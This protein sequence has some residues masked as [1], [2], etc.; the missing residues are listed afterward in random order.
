MGVPKLFRWLSE[1]YPCLSQIVKDNEVPQ[2]DNLY[3]DMNG[4]IHNCSHPCDDDVHFRLPEDQIIQDIFSYIECLFNIIK[5]KKIFFM[6]VDGVAP[7][8]KMNQQ[9][10]RRFRS[11]RDAMERERQAT[12]RGEKLSD[13]P[14]F[15][16]N[17]IT[18]GTDFMV[19]LQK[20]LEYFVA[21]KISTDELWKDIKVILSG[22]EAPGEGEHKIMDFIRTER[23]QDNYDPNT[24][25]CLYGL[26]AD[27][28][29]L[30]VSSHEPY[31][32]LLREEV[33]F[34]RSKAKHVNRVN[35]SAITFH[36]LHLTLLRDYLHHEFSSLQDKLP[37]GYDLESIIDDWI[38]MSFL[39]GNDFIPPIPHFQISKNT[40]STLYR[41]YMEVA[42][43]LDGYLNEKGHLNLKRFQKFL[44]KLSQVDFDNF[45]ETNAD[46]KY[47]NSKRHQSKEF[48]HQSSKNGHYST[49]NDTSPNDESPMISFLENSSD[50]EGT[51]AESSSENEDNLLDDEF[52]SHKRDY[53]MTK[54]H[55]EN[56]NSDVLKEQAYCYIKAIQWNLHYYYD[57]CPSW[58][59]FYPHHYAPYI[60]D[61]KSFED[62][63]LN[64]ELG[65]PFK[66]YEQLLG[67]LPTASKQFLPEAYQRLMT[68]ESSPLI[69]YF[70]EN[71][72]LDLDGKQ[73][74]WEAV[75]VIPFIDEVKLLS[76]TKSCE[77]KLSEGD[78]KQNKHGPHL[79]FTFTPDIQSHISSTL[80]G[81]LP[82]IT[83]NH[84]KVTPVSLDAY[85]LPR[86]KIKKGLIDGVDLDAYVPGFPTLRTLAHTAELKRAKVRVFE[87]SSNGFNF[88]LIVE[89]QSDPD[90]DRVIADYLDSE[91][92]INWPHLVKAK[93]T[94][95]CDGNKMYISKNGCCEKVMTEQELR[96]FR[97]HISICEESFYSRRGIDAGEIKILLY[98]QTLVGQKYS[99]KSDGEVITLNQW[100]GRDVPTPFQT[101]LKDIKI[102]EK[103]SSV[104]KTLQDLY[105]I[106]KKCF[107]LNENFYGDCGEIVEV[108]QKNK[109]I[110]VQI[111][112]LPEPELSEIHEKM[113]DL[114][115]EEY[116]TNYQMAVNLGVD[117]HLLSRLTGSLMVS[118]NDEKINIGLNLKFN[119][120]REVVPGFSKKQ[121]E[122]WLFSRKVYKLMEEYWEKFPAL[123]MNLSRHTDRDMFSPREVF[124]TEEAERKVIE[125][126]DWLKKLPHHKLKRQKFDAE[127][128]DECVVKC[129]EDV[130]DS[131]K[132]FSKP[133]EPVT[134]FLPFNQILVPS[135][136]IGQCPPDPQAS[137]KL[138]DRVVNVKEGLHVPL[139]AKGVVIGINKSGKES[140]DL[141]LD[142]VFDDPF[143]GGVQLNC[144]Q[145][146][147]Y[148]LHSS[149]VM[150]ISFKKRKND[151]G[152][153][154][155]FV[156]TPIQPRNGA[157]DKRNHPRSEPRKLINL[158]SN[159]RSFDHHQKSKS[160]FHFGQNYQTVQHGILEH[161][162]FSFESTQ[163]I[164]H[165]PKSLFRKPKES[166]KSQAE[167]DSLLKQ[168]KISSKNAP[169]T[170][171]PSDTESGNEA[172]D[173]LFARA[174]P[175]HES[176]SSIASKAHEVSTQCS[177]PA[178]LK[179]KESDTRR[180]NKDDL[181]DWCKGKFKG[182]EPKFEKH[183]VDGSNKK[184]K[185]HYSVNVRIP[186]GKVL[187]YQVRAQKNMDPEEMVSQWALTDLLAT[188]DPN[189]NG[190]QSTEKQEVLKDRAHQASPPCMP[191]TKW[192]DSTD[193]PQEDTTPL[194]GILEIPNSYV[195]K[196]R[197]L[198][199]RTKLENNT[200]G[201]SHN[202]HPTNQ[203]QKQL[204][205]IPIPVVP[206]PEQFCFEFPFIR[207]PLY[208]APFPVQPPFNLSYQQNP[209]ASYPCLPPPQLWQPHQQ[210]KHYHQ[211][212]QRPEPFHEPK[213]RNAPKVK[214][215]NKNKMVPVQVAR[216]HQQ[217]QA[218]R[219]RNNSGENKNQPAKQAKVSRGSNTKEDVIE[220]SSSPMKSPRSNS[221][222]KLPKNRKSGVLCNFNASMNEN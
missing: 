189:S 105:P 122:T 152:I 145:N 55:Y 164:N 154:D 163:K 14:R 11:A 205:P 22:H 194:P 87:M 208:R 175:N 118:V 40:L 219:D 137:Y 18:P 178:E 84:A 184:N 129:V 28:I 109:K 96:E 73:H 93:V 29:M 102:V 80:P 185:T 140:D 172:I 120:R 43:E 57:G 37:Y 25:H 133:Y 1:R 104:Y 99:I 127:C 217:E 60:S 112:R 56:V 62:I 52:V 49:S 179:M 169:P 146:R 36:L 165:S 46:L 23:S 203:H 204:Q 216:K 13:V 188:E 12:L 30:G 170:S 222:K 6:A 20:H 92:Y 119:A 32:S 45:S 141:Y 67:V 121:D 94:R 114:L 211:K 177:V 186:N 153:R 149:S 95:I 5:P 220:T 42:P 27:L 107:I 176:Y 70:P 123:F 143:P 130:L 83:L 15:D 181:I 187:S 207:Y 199:E 90:I 210:Q 160:P 100:S 39:C 10:G 7:R 171:G 195:K 151:Y 47:F 78:K 64:F 166:S 16:S 215:G 8:A 209:L 212:I 139:G 81:R 3:L 65:T 24:R 213:P 206:G 17:C 214:D 125:V 2:F 69:D 115:D 159:A 68:E 173:R 136:L 4:I 196:N 144:S 131:H 113:F 124:G 193:V 157:R 50:Q 116:M 106:G 190:N 192:V 86:D 110:K 91:I 183:P 167:M 198:L 221:A 59:W 71:F 218:V 38:L 101:S 182:Q 97:T 19:R 117:P 132:V 79:V 161:Q 54:M 108:N 200:N 33:K 35:P 58:S 138:F 21:Y 197:K 155:D 63:D 180:T 61:V 72:A 88:I 98:V 135:H 156:M 74:S 148:R 201:Q 75:V 162:S 34:T 174:N 142:I 44:A 9:R 202:S 76:A 158:N 89:N 128:L 126:G 51:N 41:V 66:P 150:N 111:S 48:K 85:H 53:Y 77:N 103:V 168:L 191:P 82:D 31:F 26:D 134:Q 147:G